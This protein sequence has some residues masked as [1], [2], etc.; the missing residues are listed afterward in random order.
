MRRGLFLLALFA[1]PLD[2]EARARQKEEP[3]AVVEEGSRVRVTLLA[4]E[5]APLIGSVLERPPGILLLAIGPDSSLR[6]IPY[7]DIE[8]LEVSQGM[9]SNTLKGAY[10]GALLLGITGLVLGLA[11]GSPNLSDDPHEG[12]RS[13]SGVAG[14]A[15][16][17]V[18]GGGIGAIVGSLG[19]R[20]RWKRVEVQ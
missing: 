10:T 13:W 18:V 12:S 15:V 8:K 4:R 16:G 17:A 14:F 11:A 7:E 2:A 6:T 3:P 9:H 20:E 1:L 19:H 5:A